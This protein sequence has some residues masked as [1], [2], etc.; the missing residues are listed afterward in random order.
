MAHPSLFELMVEFQ[1]KYPKAA[2][3]R[4]FKQIIQAILDEERTRIVKALKQLKLEP[5]GGTNG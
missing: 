4:L 1:T 2:K 5:Q 3:D